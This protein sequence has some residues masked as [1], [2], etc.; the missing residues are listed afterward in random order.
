MV[1]AK[2]VAATSPVESGVLSREPLVFR[3]PEGLRPH[4][5]HLELYGAPETNT[6]FDAIV[7]GMARE[8]YDVAQPLLITTDDRILSGVTRWTAARRLGLAKVPCEIFRARSADQAE[9]EYEEVLV[10]RNT[11][12][13]KTQRMLAR[14]QRKLLELEKLLARGRQSAK[15]SDGGPARSTDRVAA[16][17]AKDGEA[18]ES[19]RTVERRIKVLEGLEAAE[20]A[21]DTRKARQLGTLLEGRSLVKALAVIAGQGGATA[22]K[23]KAKVDSPPTHNERVQRGYSSLFDAVTTSRDLGELEQVEGILVRLAE[24]VRAMRQRL[25][26]SRKGQQTSLDTKKKSG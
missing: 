19:G 14:E 7:A 15:A 18:A 16:Q 22:A 8:G 10:A 17:F 12:R 26:G 4:G 6:A 21:G 9:L 13:V 2:K 3:D 23:A 25:G 1:R 5:L 20:R 11:Y 24:D